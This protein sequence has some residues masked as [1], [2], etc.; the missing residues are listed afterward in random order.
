MVRAAK[1]D[2]AWLAKGWSPT[3]HWLL[4]GP[5]LLWASQPRLPIAHMRLFIAPSQ[6]P[7]WT[8]LLLPSSAAPCLALG[9][10]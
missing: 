5:L 10:V 6:A 9:C 4:S 7:G 1:P 8:S 3:Q 2:Q